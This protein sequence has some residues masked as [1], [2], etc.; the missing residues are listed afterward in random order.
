MELNN[1][2]AKLEDELKVLKN[3]VQAVLL[4]LRENYLT[5]EN[6]FSY[7]SSAASPA[8]AQPITIN[9]PAPSAKEPLAADDKKEEDIAPEE[10]Q[11]NRTTE[12]SQ[13][14]YRS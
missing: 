4:D 3:E 5:H 1:K 14:R 9:Q 13:P 6:P 2:V 12:P 8:T 11:E 10:D 7:T